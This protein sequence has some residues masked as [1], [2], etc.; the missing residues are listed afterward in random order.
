MIYKNRFIFQM[1]GNEAVQN[2]VN[3]N[4]FYRGVRTRAALLGS[5]SH[6]SMQVK[7]SERTHWQRSKP[8]KR[9]QASPSSSTSQTRPRVPADTQT[10]NVSLEVVKDAR[11]L[12]TVLTRG[13][14]IGTQRA[15]STSTSSMQAVS[16]AWLRWLTIKLR[17][18][19]K[20]RSDS[21]DH[22]TPAGGRQLCSATQVPAPKAW[23]VRLAWTRNRRS[24]R[25][26]HRPVEL[27]V[28][29]FTSTAGVATSDMT[30]PTLVALRLSAPWSRRGP[31]AQ[32]S[33]VDHGSTMCKFWF[34]LPES[35]AAPRD[36][37]R[38]RR[39]TSSRHSR[40]AMSILSRGS[41]PSLGSNFFPIAFR[42]AARGARMSSWPSIAARIVRSVFKCLN[43]EPT[44]PAAVHNASAG[45]A[46]GSR[47]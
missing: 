10:G 15:P 41:W 1:R 23:R 22:R 21:R 28:V 12:R 40:L 37:K 44:R 13:F 7:Y 11:T 4:L 29:E 8:E 6:C 16:R 24:V 45:V 39:A 5:P 35:S 3:Q 14:W 26:T 38:A 27:A 42:E 31:A 25:D 46:A 20:A 36:P 47:G 18:D 43:A 2:W 17:R 32:G 34:C 19:R 30:M 33:L 9:T